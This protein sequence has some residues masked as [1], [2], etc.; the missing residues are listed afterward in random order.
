MLESVLL[1]SDGEETFSP[2]AATGG[3][4]ST[5]RTILALNTHLDDQGE[6]A[7]REGTKL[8]L[9]VASRLRSKYSPDFTFLSGDL[10]S[11]PSGDAYKILNTP[12]S[13]FVDTRRLIADDD[14]NR[15]GK[16]YAY[17]NELTFTGFQGDSGAGGKQRID[18][19]HLG[20]PGGS[21]DRVD[22][23][24]AKQMLQGYGV[25]PNRFD[26]KVWLSDHR[27]VV[28]DLLVPWGGH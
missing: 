22:L 23:E 19:I 2:P 3:A 5:R 25:L 18:F 4:F 20:I 24:Q 12:G 14:K 27:A 13:G 1:G 26:D 17:G 15:Q 6:E 28:V 21:E 11:S 16:I 9:Q 10:N 8:I 7:R